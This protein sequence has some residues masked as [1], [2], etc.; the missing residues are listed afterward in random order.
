MEKHDRNMLQRIKPPLTSINDPLPPSRDRVS[1]PPQYSTKQGFSESSPPPST[2]GTAGPVAPVTPPT[3]K[4]QSTTLP[5]LTSVSPGVAS[6]VTGLPIQEFYTSPSFA[7][8]E[9]G[10]ATV[11]FK[12]DVLSHSSSSFSARNYTEPAPVTR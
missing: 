9:G 2:L 6:T 11:A 1:P 10:E 4:P 12:A 7:K 8:Y 5:P 3:T